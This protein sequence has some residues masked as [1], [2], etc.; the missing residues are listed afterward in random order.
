MSRYEL[1]DRN[2]LELGDLAERG[3]DLTPDG[4]LALGPPES[5]YADPGLEQLIERIV[6]ARQADRP[7][8]VMMGAH[9]IK[10]GLSRFL[11]DLVERRIITHLGTNGA[12]IIHDFELAAYGGTSEDVA[13]WIGVGRFGLWRQTGRVNELAVQ[14]AARGEGLGE[15]VGRVIEEERLPHRDLSLAAA[16]WRAG[17]PLT[18][19][20]AVGCDIVHAHPNCDPAALGKATYTDF[21]I[22]ARCVQEL[23]GGVFLNVGS[24]T[25]GPEVYLKALSMARNVARPHGAEIRDFTTA[26]FDLVALP[27]DWQKG[28]PGK[29]HPLYYYRPWKTILIRTVADGG[30]SFYFRGDHRQTI[31]T[32]WDRLARRFA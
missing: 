8:I 29:E 18:S 15:A 1:F 22:F 2:Q 4:C 3:H 19:H 26:V 5:A 30:T 14:A 28:P 20:V 10:L 24:S 16:G 21:L 32:L 6:A 27:S 13:R 23:E 31:P 12:G 7:V 9:P 11:V 25:I 17:V